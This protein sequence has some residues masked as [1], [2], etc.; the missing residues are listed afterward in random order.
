MYSGKNVVERLGNAEHEH[1]A[2]CFLR[3]IYAICIVFKVVN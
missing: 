2:V 3:S 1:G